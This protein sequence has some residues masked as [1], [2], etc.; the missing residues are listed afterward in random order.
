MLR[1]AST[2]RRGD[3]V[4]NPAGGG[5]LALPVVAVRRAGQGPVRIICQTGDAFE[6]APTELMDVAA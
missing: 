4:R 6:M 2:V 5:A 3:R 1:Q